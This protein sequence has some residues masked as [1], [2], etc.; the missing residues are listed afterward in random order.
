MSGGRY[1]MTKLVAEIDRAMSCP[2]TGDGWSCFV[3]N[4]ALAALGD[5]GP[6]LLP[7]IEEVSTDVDPRM[8][9]GSAKGI[10]C[11]CC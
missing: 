11:T 5:V 9:H 6:E 4:K 2:P 7:A 1:K 8:R 3:T 10:C